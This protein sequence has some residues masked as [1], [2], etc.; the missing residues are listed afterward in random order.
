M[1]SIISFST[2]VIPSG[3]NNEAE[4]T[5]PKQYAAN[6]ADDATASMVDLGSTGEIGSARTEWY[7]T[8][9]VLLSDVMGTGVLG[10]PVV[11]VTLGWTT[12]MI[13]MPLFAFFAAYSGFQLKTAKISNPKI[14][15]YGDAGREFIG[16][17]FG[18]FAKAC[19]LL[20]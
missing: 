10:L 20:N 8:T 13:C 4:S 15:S 1:S 9:L 11:A 12:T 6:V 14:S 17:H 7:G 3:N 16:P 18:T 19:M 5:K 2:R